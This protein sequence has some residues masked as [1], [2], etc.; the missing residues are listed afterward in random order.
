M[1]YYILPFALWTTAVR[2]HGVS[3]QTLL[4]FL[5]ISFDIFADHMSHLKCLDES[6]VSQNKATRRVQYCCLAHES[7]RPHC[8]VAGSG[9]GDLFHE[10]RG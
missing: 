5:N 2:Y 3:S 6:K 7:F 1:A 9:S 8:A 10:S 4:D